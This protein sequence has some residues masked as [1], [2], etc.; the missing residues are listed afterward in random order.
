[1]RMIK[2]LAVVTSDASTK[3]SELT[4]AKVRI[5]SVSF[6]ATIFSCLVPTGPAFAVTFTGGDC[7]LVQQANAM[8]VNFCKNLTGKTVDDIH[9]TFSHPGLPNVL[10]DYG[11]NLLTRRFGPAVPPGGTWEGIGGSSAQEFNVPVWSATEVLGVNFQMRRVTATGYWTFSGEKVEPIPE[12]G[13]WAMMLVGFGAVGFV[14][15]RR[16]QTELTFRR[17]A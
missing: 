2:S 15:R 6:L 17:A 11:Q 3:G 1:M 9:V 16:R 8:R 5:A 10:V 7:A 13:T 14:L 4:L 12:P